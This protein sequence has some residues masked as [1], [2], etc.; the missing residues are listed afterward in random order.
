MKENKEE[1]KYEDALKQLSVIVEK[2]EKGDIPLE[3]TVKEYE[4]GQK[5]LKFCKEQLTSAEGKLLKLNDNG[6]I[7][8]LT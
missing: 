6:E 1:L 3:E 8:E 4:K 7:S 2:L 5:L